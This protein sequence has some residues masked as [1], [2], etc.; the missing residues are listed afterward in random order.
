VNYRLVKLSSSP[1]SLFNLCLVVDSAENRWIRLRSYS[2]ADVY[3]GAMV[4]GSGDVKEWLEIWVQTTASLA[5]TEPAE[6]KSLTNP[7]LDER[8]RKRCLVLQE[9]SQGGGYAC[10]WEA[11]YQSPMHWDPELDNLVTIV[12]AETGAAWEVCQNDELLRQC[13]LPAYSKTHQRFLWQPSL[14][15]QSLFLA[16]GDFAAENEKV[17]NAREFFSKDG[18]I[19]FNPEGGLMMVRIL[20]PLGLEDFR[21][22]ISGAKWPMPGKVLFPTQE[23]APYNRLTDAVEITQG[24]QHLMTALKGKEA[25]WAENF[26]LKLQLIADLFEKVRQVV[27]QQQMPLLTLTVDSFR[28]RLGEMACHLPTLW[29]FNVF[30]AHADDVLLEAIDADN[31]R[32]FRLSK[33]LER[34]IYRPVVV[35]DRSAG[36]G[37]LRLRTVE[38]ASNGAWVEGTLETPERINYSGSDLVYLAIPTSAQAIGVY[39]H[40]SDKES[41]TQGELRFRSLPQSLTSE[42]LAALD[43]LK[44]I[45]VETSFEVQ[46][47]IRTPGDLYSLAVIAA[48]ILLTN[49]SHTLPVAIDECLSLAKEMASTKDAGEDYSK[50][51]MSIVDADSRWLTALGPGQLTWETTDPDEIFKAIPKSLW[52]D[53]IGWLIRLFP[54]TGSG[55][56]CSD[57]GDVTPL[58]LET[59]FDS[60]IS[61]LNQLLQRAKALLFVEWAVN[62][63]IR[64]VIQSLKEQ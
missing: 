58:A 43:E 62:K 34:S 10:D 17:R 4:D 13:N 7:I 45:V 44:G 64:A 12:D 30:L 47:V 53:T 11:S 22:L 25:Y 41:L 24:S 3:A 54:G 52:W 50:R 57:Y 48:Q 21:G 18:K 37:S 20:A 26:F 6:S 14:G 61:D 15:A 8:W 32:F 51:L 55:S 16:N 29:N 40:L 38:S 31:T 19:C 35:T 39:A 23:T 46:P 27:K 36:R 9:I 1:G 63:E 33:K 28:V 56:Y 5:V 60:P 2:D 42:Q 49:D 59:V